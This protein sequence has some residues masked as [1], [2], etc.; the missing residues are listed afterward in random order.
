[1]RLLFFNGPIQ[2]GDFTFAERPGKAVGIRIAEALNTLLAAPPVPHLWNTT[3]LAGDLRHREHAAREPVSRQALEAQLIAAKYQPGSRHRGGTLTDTDTD[4]S[5]LALEMIDRLL[6]DHTLKITAVTVRRCVRCEHMTGTGPHPCHAC[7]H[8]ITRAH[9]GRH[10]I[11]DRDP[12]QPVLTRADFHGRPPAHLLG[13][14]SNAPERLILSR[15]RSHGIDLAPLGLEGL[16]LDP[17]AALHIAVLSAARKSGAE[18]A[19]MTTTQSAAANVAAHGRYFTQHDGTRLVYAVH[20]RIP[21]DQTTHL[22]RLYDVHRIDPAVRDLFV[23]WFLPLCSLRQKSGVPA[24]Q[25]AALLKFLRRVV[26][27]QPPSP[28][29]ARVEELRRA[30]RAGDMR[31]V[32]N[33]HTLPHGIPSPPTPPET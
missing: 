22:E 7:G 11:A 18:D 6:T 9:T 17:R 21:Y 24:A 12:A 28:D 26:L 32:M 19:V 1:M 14:A 25:L 30:I 4:V 31:W 23:N 29:G 5:V 20:G 15:T 27:A 2:N 3:T 8:T 10:L 13:I 33:I 16:V